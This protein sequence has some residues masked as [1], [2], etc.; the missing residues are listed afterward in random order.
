MKDVEK[1]FELTTTSHL[2]LLA[3]AI[4]LYPISAR[5]N[6]SLSVLAVT[7]APCCLAL[8]LLNL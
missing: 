8:S 5:N 1:H 3:I 7:A 2:Y 4:H 6:L